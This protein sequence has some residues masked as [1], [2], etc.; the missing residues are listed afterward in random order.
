V[1][2]LVGEVGIANV[3]VVSV[4]ERRGEI[5]LRRALGARRMHVAAQFLVESSLLAL[6]GGVGGVA[7][8]RSSAPSQGPTRRCAQPG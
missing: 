8:P 6:A 1:A 7:T 4:L 5:G 3:M 2:I